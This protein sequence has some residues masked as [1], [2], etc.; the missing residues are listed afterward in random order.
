VANVG[1]SKARPRVDRRSRSARA[2]GTSAREALLRAAAEVFAERGFREASVEEIAER[3]GYS[4]GALYWHFDSKDDLFFALMDESVHAPTREMIALL[5]SAPPEQDMSIEA[6]RRFVE[7]LNGQRELLL[8]E[9]EYWSQAARDPWLRAR[10]VTH[11]DA[12]RRALAKALD[13][14]LQHL[15]AP[16]L[17]TAAEE[18]A[19]IMLG[20]GAGLARERLIDPEA[21]PEGLLGKALVL[22]YRG[23]LATAQERTVVP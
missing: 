19:T 18:M 14:R 1:T 10:Y 2:E 11:R 16:R 8:L 12:L 5:E 17:D 22:L 13:V 21:V 9:Q 3:A 7:L 20:L 6:S 23:V 4:K 15:G